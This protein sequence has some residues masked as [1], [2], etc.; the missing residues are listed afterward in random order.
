MRRIQAVFLLDEGQESL[1]RIT[2][3]T[4]LKQSR[5]FGL[6]RLYLQKGLKA[7]LYQGSSR[8]WLTPRQIQELKRTLH[9]PQT[10]SRIGYADSFWT[11]KRL[12]D[13]I[14]LAYG[15]TYKSRTSYYL[16]FKRVQFTYHKPAKVFVK[17]DEAEVKRWRQETRPLLEEAWRDKETVILAGDEMLLSTATTLQK[18]WLPQGQSPK[19]EVSN[20]RKNLSLYGFLN[21][22]TGQEH[23]FLTEKQTMRITRRILQRLR[24]IYPRRDNPGNHLKGKRLLVLW[25]NPGWHRGSRVRDYVKKDGKIEVIFFPKYAPE[26]NPQEHVWKEGR[27]KVTHNTFIGNLAQAAKDLVGYLNRTRFHYSLLGFLSNPI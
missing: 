12:A 9:N 23:A 16:I 5:I 26:E 19:I 6:R 25:D 21:L 8:S 18:I 7:L 4:G 3:I 2:L 13:Y 10:L 27:S 1:E 11:T 20:T 24:L 17:R 14:R 15:V 22:K